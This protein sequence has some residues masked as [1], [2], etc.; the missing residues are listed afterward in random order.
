MAKLLTLADTDRNDEATINKVWDALENTNSKRELAK[1]MAYG[2][3]WGGPDKRG[4]RFDGY[5]IYN[6]ACARAR[7]AGHT[8]QHIDAYLPAS[9]GGGR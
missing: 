6:A 5:H 3:L 7:E 4:E 9:W 2:C 1:V 8:P